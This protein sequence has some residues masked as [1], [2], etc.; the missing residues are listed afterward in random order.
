MLQRTPMYGLCEHI[1]LQLPVFNTVFFL[2]QRNLATLLLLLRHLTVK[3]SKQ[4]VE[5]MRRRS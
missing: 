2:L 5:I 3:V 1:H 4:P